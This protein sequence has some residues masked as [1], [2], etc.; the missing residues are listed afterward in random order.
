MAKN[1]LGGEKITKIAKYVT[2]D[3]GFITMQ[4]K[5]LFSTNLKALLL[6]LL[7]VKKNSI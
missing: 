3:R 1:Y 7:Y 5:I 4:F 6:L 2:F